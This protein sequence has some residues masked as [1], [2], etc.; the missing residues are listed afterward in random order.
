MAQEWAVKFY[1][2]KPWKELRWQ[3]LVN[4]NFHCEQ[5]GAD[6]TLEPGKLVGHHSVELNPENILRPEIALNPSLI[7]VLCKDCHNLEH[8]RYGFNNQ[9]NVTLI[10]GPPCA[11]KTQL[12][13]QLSERGDLIV[14]MDRLY[15]AVS[16]CDLYD[17]PDSIKRNV[18][19]VRDL[20]IDQIR[21]RLG[22]WNDAF[23]VGGYARKIERERLVTRLGA[24][25]QLVLLPEEQCKC[26]ARA[27]RG[28]HAEAWCRYIEKWF[29][30][31]QA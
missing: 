2:S 22:G 17:K 25:T 6:Y 27:G 5:C 19:G 12:V 9:H 29:A 26:R 7:T 11:G 20:L 28:V 31:Y 14:D 1:N 15:A 3:K 16:G 23:I 8:N 4:A 13:T 10:Y 21:M 24:K 30:S 18:F